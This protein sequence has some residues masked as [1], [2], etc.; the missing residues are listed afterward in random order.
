MSDDQTGLNRI[1]GNYATKRHLSK[2]VTCQE[3]QDRNQSHCGQQVGPQSIPY[4]VGEMIWPADRPCKA[5]LYNL[6]SGL[7]ADRF[8]SPWYELEAQLHICTAPT[9]LMH[10]HISSRLFL[11][12]ALRLHSFFPVFSAT[13]S[14]GRH[15]I[16]LFRG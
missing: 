9:A 11:Q 6:N 8:T 12:A 14:T 3:P 15:K 4:P 16:A 13:Q 10:C 1:P 5:L 2:Q 7:F